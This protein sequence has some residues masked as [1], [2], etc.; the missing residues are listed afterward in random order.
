MINEVHSLSELALHRDTSR[1]LYIGA[2]GFEKRALEALNAMLRSGWRLNGAILLTY[3]GMNRIPEN[4]VSVS[5]MTQAATIMSDETR[6]SLLSE[7]DLSDIA[8]Q[9]AAAAPPQPELLL[10]DISGM[11]HCLMLQVLRKLSPVPLPLLIVYSEA[12]SY[13]PFAEDVD[14]ILRGERSDPSTALDYLNSI[15]INEGAMA[16]AKYEY[17]KRDFITSGVFEVHA[18]PGYEGSIC[19]QLPTTL[20]VFPTFR[21]VRTGAIIAGLELGRKAFI[22]GRPVRDELAWRTKV[23]QMINYDLMDPNTDNICETPTLSPH[24]SYQ[25]LAELADR[26]L[27]SEPRNLL[28]VPL[29]SKMQ[30]VG[31][32]RFCIEHPEAR[33]VLSR[34]RTFFPNRY[35]DGAGEVFFFDPQPPWA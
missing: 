3:S 20:I 22:L 27:S 5:R 17:E 16:F 18:V 15:P 25:A 4:D 24:A 21:R 23:L 19:P 30:T 14:T 29:G 9:I 6:V 34:P 28:I 31:V 2:A 35:S 12:A 32:W 8:E 11:S 1:A 10:V 13:R 7:D 26:E 33:L